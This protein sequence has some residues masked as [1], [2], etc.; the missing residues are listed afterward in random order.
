MFKLLAIQVLEGCEEHIKRCLTPG[1]MY[2]LCHDYVISQTAEDVWHVKKG[3]A[4]IANIDEKFFRIKRGCKVRVNISAIVGENGSGKSTIVELILRMIN[5]CAIK[6]GIRTEDGHLEFVEGVRARLFYQNGDKICCLIIEGGLET[7]RVSE[8]ATMAKGFIK[9]T[10]RVL[11][12]KDLKGHFFYTLVSNYSHYAY[13]TNDFRKEWNNK[14]DEDTCW[15]KWIFHK[16]DGYQTPVTLHPFREQGTIN[17][18]REKT[19]SNQRLLF[20]LI[21][22][23]KRKEEKGVFGYINGKRPK[24]LN[25][26]EANSSKLQKVTLQNYLRNCRDV[27]LLEDEIQYLEELKIPKKKMSE[28]Q[29]EE[30]KRRIFLPLK[31]IAERVIGAGKNLRPLHYQFFNTLLEWIVQQNASI[32]DADAKLLSNNSDLKRILDEIDDMRMRLHYDLSMYSEVTS[33]YNELRPFARL[34]ICQIQRLEILDDVCDFWSDIKR[35]D[36]TM[37]GYRFAMTPK[38]ITEDYKNLSLEQ[39][40]YHYI[41]YKTID[42]F[43]TYP[44]FRYPL[45]AYQKTAVHFNRK[46]GDNET[47]KMLRVAFHQLLDDV[48]QEK[49]HITLK[50][51]QA[52]YYLNHA[53]KDGKDSFYNDGEIVDGIEGICLSSEKLSDLYKEVNEQDLETLPPPIYERHLLFETVNGTLVDMDTF[54]SGE[55]QLLNTQSVIIYHLQNLNSIFNDPVRMSYPQVNIILEEIELYFHP[56]YQRSFIYSL[57]NLLENSGIDDNIKDV[58]VLIVTHSPFVLSDIPKSNVLF[59]KNGEPDTDMQENTFGANIHS[60][61]TSGFF[62]PSLPIGEFA[63]DKINRMFESFNRVRIDRESAVERDRLYSD[64]SRVGEPYLKEQLMR[65][66]NMYYP[67]CYH[68]RSEQETVS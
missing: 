20:F 19:L 16:N 6:F 63:H 40:C 67:P 33:L 65:L 12:D 31:E 53:V 47:K 30:F 51:R 29:M 25:L 23:A 57:I 35:M 50:M 46:E 54:S 42:I 56:E 9:P 10:M 14:A 38:C 1:L 11:T 27:N 32:T 17:M 62:L 45:W 64:I 21:N 52:F 5:N 28:N 7:I 60:M 59:L 2:Y 34:N 55:K 61:L 48:T 49:T 58:N 22:Y 66:F 24:Y 43:E 44:R 39:R 15:L 36:E 13:N 41:V 18:E 68:D 8:I 26:R 3:D 37:A 4:Y